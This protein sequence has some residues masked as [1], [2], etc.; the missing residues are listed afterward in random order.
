MAAARG[1]PTHAGDRNINIVLIGAHP[2]DCEIKAGGTCAKW[3][4]AGF[5][6]HIVC[7]TNGDAGHH[8]IDRDR[9]ASIRIAEAEAAAAVI[10]A[11]SI[12]L[13]HHDGEL[14]PTLEV[15]EKVISIIRRFRADVVITH[16][17]ND[18]HPDHRYTSQVVQDAAYM[19]TVPHVATGEAALTKNPVFLYF[20]DP[21][22]KPVP[23]EAHIAVDLAD[24]MATKLKMMDAMSSQVYEW[25]A[26]HDGVLDQVPHDAAERLSWLEETWRPSFHPAAARGREALEKWYG[27]AAAAQVEYAELFEISEYGHQPTDEELR[28]IFPFFPDDHGD[29]RG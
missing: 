12:V 29:N 4:E 26:W 3:A 20:M 22:K 2:D 11:K 8:E 16:R 6:L 23:F 1:P 5:N 9:L 24:S 19:V 15:R 14:Q 10:G 17:P 28:A 13:D 21:F 7:M 25:L 27:K 18:Y